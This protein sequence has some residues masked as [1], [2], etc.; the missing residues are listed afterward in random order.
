MSNSTFPKKLI[1]V[2]LPLEAIN[3]A[4]AY[5][6]MPGIGSHPKGIHHWWAR[7]PLPCARAMLFASL[8]ND[9]SSDPKWVNK[10]E[11]EQDKERNR[12]F[13]II[14]SLLH[15]DK[16]LQKEAFAKAVVEIERSCDGKT[17]TLLDPFCGGGSIP[18]EAQRL[19]LNVQGSDLNPVAVL[20]T[21]AAIEIIPK[22]AGHSPVNPAAK[23]TLS[24]P[25]EWRDAKGLANDVRYYAKW[26][27]SKADR[28][29]GHLYPKVSLP[30]EYGGG[31]ANLVAL[32]WAR[33]VKCQNPTC[34]AM[35]P[36]VRSFTLAK[37]KGKLIWVEPIVD[38][39]TYPPRI[40]FRVRIDGSPP[41]GTVSRGGARCIA[42]QDPM[43][44]DGIA[45]AG[46]KGE[47]KP[48]LMVIVA[49][50]KRG[51]VYLSPTLEQQNAAAVAMTDDAPDT[52]LPA[53]ALG[54]RI[55]R[56]GMAKHRDMFTP[57]QLKTL[58]LLSNLVL[59]A[60]AKILTDAN[61]AADAQEYADAICLFLSFAVDRC[62][63]FNSSLCRWSSG[64]EKVMS[65]FGLHAIPMVWDFAEANLLGDGVGGWLPRSDY[66]A[67]CIETIPIGHTKPGQASQLD[68]VD[69]KWNG[70]GFFL[71]TD[72]PYYDNMGYADLS[73]VFYVWLR[74]SIGKGFR[75]ICS[76]LLVPKGPELVA[77]PDRFDGDANA[78]KQHFE[79]GFRKA[80]TSLKAKLDS[81]FPMTIYYAFKQADEEEEVENRDDTI[82]TRPAV[83]TGWETMLEALISSSFQITGTWPVR[84]SQA[85]R[86]RANASNALASYIILVC[87]PLPLQAL[88]A[89][90]REFI[91]ALRQELPEAL[92]KLRNC[93]IAPVDLAQATI[94]PGMAI[95]S[96]YSSILEARSS[97]MSV[98]TA[99]QIIN[100][101]LDAF[102]DAQDTELDRETRFCITW[103]EQHGYERGAF[104]EADVLARA[105]NTSVAT[106]SNLDLLEAAGGY[107]RIIKREENRKEN[108]LSHIEHPT[109]WMCTQELIRGLEQG[110]EA[111]AASA[112][113]QIGIGLSELSKDLAYRMFSICEKK[114]MAEEALAY[115]NLVSSWNS[116]R[117]KAGLSTGPTGQMRLEA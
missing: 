62:V 42:C 66:V 101:E 113:N 70:T 91:N 40:D 89:S 27:E 97:K 80:F 65:L 87:R 68:A 5:D 21:K 45:A 71:S 96:R 78:A 7:L 6:K 115:N 58:T 99:L 83:A 81:R 24:K 14:R 76:T 8:V 75:D 85:W 44:H 116:I 37:K 9:P 105:K 35:P 4:S 26:I 3:D 74:R 117:E 55:Q 36:L 48:Q 69:A 88:P 59:E 56:Y 60:H 31:N 23:E 25:T 11:A 102:L 16:Y 53:K 77:S 50:G 110:G 47:I 67:E 107:V 111:K 43:K 103:F 38:R 94:G 92:T 46:R 28:Q 112:V 114:G 82:E 109:I 108:E 64:N 51:R 98:R 29:V 49:S 90:R 52:D 20:I 63:E 72:P 41:A 18:L 79:T 33:T 57:R 10:S 61:G 15:K 2:A 30:K 22:F 17:P 84:A 1:E 12:L 39:R 104:G 19:G 106:L 86:M 100:Q 73:D 32:L 93:N 13:D 95:F 54:F 34:G